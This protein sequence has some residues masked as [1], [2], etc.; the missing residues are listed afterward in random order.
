MPSAVLHKWDDIPA[1][2]L[3]PG[4]RRRFLTAERVTI[5]RFN[6]S[7]GAVV[8]AHAHENE[9][10]S[11]VVRGALRFFVD[12]QETVVRTGEALQIPS[13]AEHRVE[14]IED[15][16]VID[17]FSPV[18]EDWLAGTDNYFGARTGVQKVQEVQEVQGVQEVLGVLGVLGVQ[19]VP[20]VRGVQL[21]R[22]D[23]RPKQSD[24]QALSLRKSSPRASP[25]V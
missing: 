1:Q 17:V 23:I 21:V 3:A 2:E 8:P 14:V 5:A 18:R 16:E 20:K 13:R 9:Q 11:Y 24:W 7:A 6:L 4:I 15:T 25:W 19:W 22:P 12:G 10:V